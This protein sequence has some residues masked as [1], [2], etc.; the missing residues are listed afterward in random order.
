MLTL[1]RGRTQECK[2]LDPIGV[3][4]RRQPHGFSEP[5]SGVGAS[6][7]TQAGERRQFAGFFPENSTIER[8]QSVAEF[9][10]VDV[11]KPRG[12]VERFE[13]TARNEQRAPAQEP[14]TM[15]L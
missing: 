7:E 11:A 2:R 12:D 5:D 1:R 9:I 10:G 8:E 4:V 3:N 6:T 13:G 15:V 14:Q